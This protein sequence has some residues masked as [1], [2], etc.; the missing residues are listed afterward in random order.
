MIFVSGLQQ[1]GGCWLSSGRYF[2]KDS[3]AR[4]V[5]EGAKTSGTKRFI[6]EE[7]IAVR[8]TGWKE[9]T[10]YEWEVLEIPEYDAR[11]EEAI[12]AYVAKMWPECEGWEF[13]P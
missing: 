2:K 3:H 9:G 10:R 11:N 13:I 7:Y 6:L 5:A 4:A 12:N 8:A 1:V